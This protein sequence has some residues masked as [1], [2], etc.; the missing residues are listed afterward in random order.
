MLDSKTLPLID[1]KNLPLLKLEHK[2]A[3]QIQNVETQTLLA[4]IKQH[5]IHGL[6]HHK[7][8]KLYDKLI[9]YM[10]KTL[11]QLEI[12]NGLILKFRSFLSTTPK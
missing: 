1:Q 4:L 11:L 12:D 9:N 3:H 2:M 5:I 10:F 7:N 6:K 8:L